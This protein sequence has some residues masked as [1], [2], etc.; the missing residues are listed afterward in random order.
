[1]NKDLKIT[2]TL[3]AY[4][5][6]MSLA[7]GI[8]LIFLVKDIKQRE[9]CMSDLIPPDYKQCQAEIPN[10]VNFMT[11]GGRPKMIRCKNKPAFIATENEPGADGKIGS[12]SL[13]TD[14]TD[15]LKRQCGDD[16]ATLT[17]INTH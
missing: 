17:P 1:M 7:V 10:G 15:T 12:M 14:C 4:G 13:C 11:L 16:F 9:S 8:M 2:V 3:L 5:L 6:A